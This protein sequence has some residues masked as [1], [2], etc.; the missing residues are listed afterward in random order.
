MVASRWHEW[1]KVM[2]WDSVSNTH[3][4][5][6]IPILV[7]FVLAWLELI[8]W[9]TLKCLV[10]SGFSYIWFESILLEICYD[11]HKCH[12]SSLVTWR[13]AC[14]NWKFALHC[15]MWM[16][17]KILRMWLIIVWHLGVNAIFCVINAAYFC[18]CWSLCFLFPHQVWEN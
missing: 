9:F 11:H 7:M 5:I 13:S 4:V 10:F 1:E 17:E 12:V 8:W 18:R 14:L 15:Q 3:K 16:D 6:T 2:V